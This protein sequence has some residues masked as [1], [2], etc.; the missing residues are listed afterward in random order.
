M[1]DPLISIILTTYNRANYLDAAIRA[2]L[3]QTYRDFKLYILD[4]ASTDGTQELVKT[5][6]EDERI[7]YCRR[8]NNIGGIKNINS[9]F[10]KAAGS[11]YV[12]LTH[13][14][15]E[16]CPDLI[17]R[18][19]KVLESDGDIVLASSNVQKAGAD[20]NIIKERM[21]NVD[22]DIVYQKNEYAAKFC[23]GK[24]YLFLPSTVFRMS[25]INEGQL[26]FRED[27][28]PASD[29]YLF[30]EMNAIGK[31]YFISTPLYKYRTHPGQDS[32][33]TSI[34]RQTLF[35]QKTEILLMKLGMSGSV[36]SLRATIYR[37][38]IDETIRLY[39]SGYINRKT[40]D[41]RICTI[42]SYKDA[43][44]F[45]SGKM[46]L[47]ILFARVLPGLL[48]SFEKLKGRL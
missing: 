47:R 46:R 12:I 25:A 21:I 1:K 35:L 26:R 34:D 39:L 10:E 36:P 23:A 44:P 2:I 22:K 20:M 40:F 19:V 48:R 7:E 4:N 42:A 45:T 43:A 8:G 13:D 41:E 33:M 37:G 24:A 38:I 30:F 27:V 17:K 11:K 28:G 16:M 32:V 14:D 5:Y 6:L 9:G 18:A 3:G 15:D 31:A 29:I